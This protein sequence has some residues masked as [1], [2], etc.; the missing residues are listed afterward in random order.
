[1][2]SS[3][4]RPAPTRE[5]RGRDW[6]SSRSSKSASSSANPFL[7]AHEAAEAAAEA[8]EDAAEKQLQE[9]YDNAQRAVTAAKDKQALLT[10]QLKDVKA[11]LA[12]AEKEFKEV[13][14]LR[15]GVDIDWGLKS[16]G[17]GKKTGF[18]IASLKIGAPKPR[19]APKQKPTGMDLDE[20]ANGRRRSVRP[21]AAPS[22]EKPTKARRNVKPK[23]ATPNMEVTTVGQLKNML[24]QL[25][26]K[27]HPG[28]KK[29]TKEVVEKLRE[30]L[31]VTLHDQASNNEHHLSAPE[32]ASSV[33][34]VS[35]HFQLP[36]G[37][38][39]I[40]SL[41]RG[42]VEAAIRS[43][44]AGPSAMEGGRRRR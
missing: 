31:R 37:E 9:R 29:D 2:T 25:I 39:H 28:M 13:V 11:E 40:T 12:T 3:A 17:K 32:I 18:S 5:K 8:A 22:A 27:I 4:T 1:M 14:R 44:L 21:A 35:S 36:I 16:K 24:I 30:Q 19:A 33:Q 10:Q 26:M 15:T 7:R 23:K 41:K 20:E 34:H 38:V 42:D 43:A 6:S